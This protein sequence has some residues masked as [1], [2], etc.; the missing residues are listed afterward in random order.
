MELWHE[1]MLDNLISYF[2]TKEDVLGVLLFGSLSNPELPQDYW[3]DIDLLV[4]VKDDQLDKFF[5][6]IKWIDFFGELYTYDQS[7][8]GYKYT[9]RV[10]FDNF[11]RVD[12]VFTTEEQ[13]ASIDDWPSIPFASGIEIIFSRSAIINQMARRSYPQQRM[14][15][16]AERQF[17][18]LVRDFRFKSMLA[19]YKVVR[20]DLLI[21]LH[22]AQDLIRDCCVLG[23]M[24]RDRKLGT[25]VHKHGGPGNQ[26]V[27][28]LE[29]AQQSFKSS[30]ILESIK[31]SNLIF[32]KL[33]RE[34]SNEYQDNLQPLLNW[35]DKAKDELYG[36]SKIC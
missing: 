36:S 26:L 17:I 23:M 24:L 7:S 9:T 28:A 25:T 6:P 22:L 16:A 15:P 10:C 13:L 11:N 18:E 2:E 8:D 5:P 4:V 34:W 31:E 29:K 12:F 21:A 35:I 3:S 1:V 27:V 14:Q 20:D 30:G 33:A 32:E 19:I